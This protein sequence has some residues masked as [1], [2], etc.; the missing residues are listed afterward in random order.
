MD[1]VNDEE[2]V[3]YIYKIENTTFTNIEEFFE[4]SDIRMVT[5]HSYPLHIIS[6]PTT[7]KE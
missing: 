6:I 7:V 4:F 2:T 3:K 1:I 5:N